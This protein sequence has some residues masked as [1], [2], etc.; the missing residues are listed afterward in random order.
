MIF[1]FNI[2]EKELRLT[3]ALIEKI[4]ANPQEPSVEIEEFSRTIYH[5][6]WVTF[7]KGDNIWSEVV[8]LAIELERYLPNATTEDM[9]DGYFGQKRA[10]KLSQNCLQII[11]AV[12]P[13]KKE[14]PI[15]LFLKKYFK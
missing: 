9:L 2:H 13:R 10:L 5:K 12:L 15:L 3:A 8:H 7:S 14:N 4:L 11:N 1:W 6:R